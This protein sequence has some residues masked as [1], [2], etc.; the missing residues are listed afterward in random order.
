VLVVVRDIEREAYP[1]VIGA[2]PK[3]ARADRSAS[4]A[5]GGCWAPIVTSH[6]TINPRMIRNRFM[7]PPRLDAGRLPASPSFDPRN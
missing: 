7:T 2:V 5:A 6:A 3:V 4:V 1:F